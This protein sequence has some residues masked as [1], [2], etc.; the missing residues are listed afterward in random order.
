MVT[1]QEDFNSFTPM[2][3]ARAQTFLNDDLS[4]VRSSREQLFSSQQF[5][6]PAPKQ[7][8]EAAS[9]SPEYN[10]TTVDHLKCKVVPR[11]IGHARCEICFDPKVMDIRQELDA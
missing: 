4:P 3:R 8:F 2:S 10:L 1:N 7:L 11:M 9:L 5:T 6:S